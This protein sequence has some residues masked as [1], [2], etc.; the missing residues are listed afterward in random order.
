MFKTLESK[1]LQDLGFQMKDLMLHCIVAFNGKM[2]SSSYGVSEPSEFWPQ[3]HTLMDSGF[4][5]IRIGVWQLV[6]HGH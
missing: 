4:L 2:V 3:N 5:V 1:G 6:V